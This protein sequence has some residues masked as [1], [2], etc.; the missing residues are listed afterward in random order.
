MAKSAGA[1]AVV[2][3]IRISDAAKAKVKVKANLE[4]GWR[5]AQVTRSEPGSSAK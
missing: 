2:N 4:S 5:Q 1:R 3:N